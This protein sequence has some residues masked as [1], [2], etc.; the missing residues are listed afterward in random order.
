[1]VRYLTPDWAMIFL[2]KHSGEPVLITA[3]TIMEGHG[4]FLRYDEA[5]R[6]WL[7]HMIGDPHTRVEE[8]P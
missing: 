7:V 5:S 6:R 3:P 8:L 4:L 1:M 2:G